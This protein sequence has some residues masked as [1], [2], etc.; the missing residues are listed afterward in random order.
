[1][2]VIPVLEIVGKLHIS[3]VPLVV[4]IFTRG[5]TE[6]VLERVLE[7]VVVK[8]LCVEQLSTVRIVHLREGGWGR[9][10]LDLL[11]SPG[12]LGG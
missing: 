9:G 6:R 7:R 1:M 5:S 11:G 8:T 10:V 12:R 4:G 2:F 3:S